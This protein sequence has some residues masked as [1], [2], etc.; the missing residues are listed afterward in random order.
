M[1]S[2]VGTVTTPDIVA[3]VADLLLRHERISWTFCTGQFRKDIII[4]IRSSQANARAGQL[5]RS[6]LKDRRNCG[7]HDTYAGGKMSVKD[8]PAGTVLKMIDEIQVNFARQLGV[9]KVKWKDLI[10]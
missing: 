6:L 4:S 1:V 10:I 5:I 2:D 3:E 9:K 8:L 7:G